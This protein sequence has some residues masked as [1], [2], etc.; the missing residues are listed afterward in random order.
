M[1]LWATLTSWATPYPAPTHSLEPPD[2]GEAFS[3]HSPPV[4]PAVE[5]PQST[6]PW[7]CSHQPPLAPPLLWED[8]GPLVGG[9]LLPLSPTLLS[10]NATLETWAPVP[11]HG[12][13]PGLLASAPRIRARPAPSQVERRGRSGGA[14]RGARPKVPSGRTPRSLC[15]LPARCSAT[16]RLRDPASLDRQIGDLCCHQLLPPGPDVGSTWPPPRAWPLPGTPSLPGGLA[17]NW[18]ADS[19]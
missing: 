14:R 15:A 18:A 5:T 13:S 7:V 17:S 16:C 3:S 12:G 11:S 9:P 6:P 4:P 10:G 8:H 19:P 2:H 1:E